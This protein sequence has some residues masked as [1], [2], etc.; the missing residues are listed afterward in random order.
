MCEPL[1]RS[2]L[3]LSIVNSLQLADQSE[4]ATCHPSAAR[5]GLLCE[6]VSAEGMET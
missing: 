5:L 3:F 4:R 2:Y 1:T 6:Q